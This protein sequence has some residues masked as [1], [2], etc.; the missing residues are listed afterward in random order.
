MV[1]KPRKRFLFLFKWQF[2]HYNSPNNYALVMYQTSIYFL[3]SIM[4]IYII[5]VLFLKRFLENILHIWST[6]LTFF[7][8]HNLKVKFVKCKLYFNFQISSHRNHFDL[9]IVK[10]N[11]KELNFISVH[12]SSDTKVTIR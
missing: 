10:F 6:S 9:S 7:N 2:D 11:L 1:F 8:N 5:I 3:D 12:S 4:K